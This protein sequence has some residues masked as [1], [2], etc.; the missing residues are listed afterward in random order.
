MRRQERAI[1]Y[2]VVPTAHTT[3]AASSSK[4]RFDD[5][6]LLFKTTFRTQNL[7]HEGTDVNTS[8][9]LSR[10]KITLPYRTIQYFNHHGRFHG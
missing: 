6:N 2:T 9:R 4:D 8:Q 7:S 1:S 10:V 3:R 5:K